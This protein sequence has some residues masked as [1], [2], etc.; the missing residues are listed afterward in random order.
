MSPTY[1]VLSSCFWTKVMSF[2]YM[3]EIGTPANLEGVN[4]LA[5][6]N[7]A[8]CVRFDLQS[9]AKDYNV[10]Y[11]PCFRME[12]GY[13]G[14][15][16]SQYP[17]DVWYWKVLLIFLVRPFQQLNVLRWWASQCLETRAKSPQQL[18]WTWRESL[19]LTTKR[20]AAYTTTSGYLGEVRTEALTPQGTGAYQIISEILAQGFW[21]SFQN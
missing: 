19:I 1:L 3:E 18:R 17:S 10:N 8:S 6:L 16:W 11:I 13:C 15:R 12:S 21:L 7:Y 5:N 9:W 2:N 20:P 14:I 4:H